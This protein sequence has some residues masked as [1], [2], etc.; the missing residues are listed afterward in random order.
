MILP[1]TPMALWSKQADM[2]YGLARKL[3][4]FGLSQ[5]YLSTAMAFGFD[6]F[7]DFLWHIVFYQHVG[8]EASGTRLNVDDAVFRF[9]QAASV[10]AVVRDHAGQAVAAMSKKMWVP[11]SPLEAEAKAMEEA[12]DFAWDIGL[13]DV[14]FE[15]DLEFL[16]YGLDVFLIHSLVIYELTGS[17]V[18]RIGTV[19]VWAEQGVNF[20]SFKLL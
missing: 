6:S 4:Q 1:V 5:A 8:D 11:L 15:C 17:V 10:G 19:V 16:I 14:V 20:C 3:R 18:I 7:L 9:L 13:Q 12:I 2:H